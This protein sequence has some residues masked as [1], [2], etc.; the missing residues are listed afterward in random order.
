MHYIAVRTI[1]LSAP[2]SVC[3]RG[4][5]MTVTRMGLRLTNTYIPVFFWSFWLRHLDLSSLYVVNTASLEGGRRRYWRRPPTY[6]IG[7]PVN[8]ALIQDDSST[9]GRFASRRWLEPIKKKYPGLSYGD[10]YT[11]A[12]VTA[13]EK[14]GGPTIK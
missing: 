9:F 10:L 7:I 4:V 6:G 1:L 13:V 3:C 12:G 14:M 11:L 8:L 5:G 2:T